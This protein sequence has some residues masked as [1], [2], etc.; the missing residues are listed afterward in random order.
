MRTILTATL[1]AM[2]IGLVGTA[3][4]SAA[5]ANGTAIGSATSSMIELAQ[6]GGYGYGYRRCWREY[7]CDYYG[8]C[9]YVRRCNY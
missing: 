9:S 2:G 7:V 1:I 8:R 3:G 4:V 5:P 6:Y